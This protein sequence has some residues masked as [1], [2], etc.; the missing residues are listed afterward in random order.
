MALLPRIDS[1]PA[2]LSTNLTTARQTSKTSFGDRMNAGLDRRTK[3]VLLTKGLTAD[4][5]VQ[6]VNG[7]NLTNAFDQRNSASV[8]LHH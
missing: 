3:N 7:K 5:A 4:G 2:R 6:L 8:S 1:T